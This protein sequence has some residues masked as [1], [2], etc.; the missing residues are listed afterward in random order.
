[1]IKVTRIGPFAIVYVFGFVHAAQGQGIIKNPFLVSY[2]LLRSLGACIHI[3]AAL[4]GFGTSTQGRKQYS[5][6][7]SV[8]LGPDDF[9]DT[10]ESPESEASKR[11]RH[12]M[13]WQDESDDDSNDYF[14]AV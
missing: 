11:A 13:N 14:D 8:A 10:T 4:L 3:N 2:I 12:R 7:P 5:V 9:P 1:M 6:K